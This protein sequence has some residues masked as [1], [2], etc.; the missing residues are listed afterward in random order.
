MLRKKTNYNE[1]LFSFFSLVFISQLSDTRH[2]TY[3]QIQNFKKLFSNFFR[4]TKRLSR[5]KLFCLNYAKWSE[6][7]K[8]DRKVGFSTSILLHCAWP[9]SQLKH[10]NSH[11]SSEHF[12]GKS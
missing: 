4:E 2:C 8:I 9:G 11:S 6:N 7:F 3:N 1:I 12:E 5:K 10:F